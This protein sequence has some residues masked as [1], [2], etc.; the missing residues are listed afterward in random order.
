MACQALRGAADPELA[1]VGAHRERALLGD[2]GA[3]LAQPRDR[4]Q[5]EAHV[6]RALAGAPARRGDLARLVLAARPAQK[7]GAREDRALAEHAAASERAPRGE[8]EPSLAFVELVELEVDLRELALRE[9]DAVVVFAA[10]E[11]RERLV[12]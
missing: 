8:R 11:R 6:E 4:A 3:R 1:A 9:H 7:R 2:G 12:E 5:R 10:R